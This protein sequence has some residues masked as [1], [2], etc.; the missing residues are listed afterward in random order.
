MRKKSRR[1]C[2]HCMLTVRTERDRCSWVHC[3]KCGKEGPRKHSVLLALIAW[4][5]KTVDQ[6]PE[7]AAM[8]LCFCGV[9]QGAHAADCPE[10]DPASLEHV[11]GSLGVP[12]NDE[13]ELT[14]LLEKTQRL[15]D[16]RN[17]E[18]FR[19]QTGEAILAEAQRRD[20]DAL[21]TRDASMPGG[22]RIRFVPKHVPEFL[23]PNKPALL[24]RQAA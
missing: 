15:I 1:R 2:D 5:V 9:I 11:I 8:S 3:D 21:L 10:Y 6:Q 13:A 20:C 19:Y 4:A 23:D 7:D 18:R 17:A 12:R 24:R 14:A 22:F 16:Q